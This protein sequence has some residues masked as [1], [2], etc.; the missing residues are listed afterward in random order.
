MSK[1]KIFEDLFKRKISN[2]KVTLFYLRTLNY[3]MLLINS[4]TIL[5]GFIR[6]STRYSAGHWYIGGGI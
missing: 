3:G 1:I 4:L 6:I 5:D 2:D